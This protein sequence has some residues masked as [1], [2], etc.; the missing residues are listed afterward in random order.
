MTFDA[1]NA[2]LRD[3]P[4]AD[5]R[6]DHLAAT[7]IAVARVVVFE[8]RLAGHLGSWLRALG[9]REL[10]SVYLHCPPVERALRVVER[11]TSRDVRERI[12]GSLD[13][14]AGASFEDVLGH[15][16]ASSDPDLLRVA[17]QLRFAAVRD[18]NDQARIRSVY[19][20]DY[21]DTS[22]FDHCVD[23]SLGD[24]ASTTAAVLRALPA[25]GAST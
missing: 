20:I 7:A 3:D 5:V 22:V 9:R 15:L 17:E 11:A 24:P 19:G 2:L 21:T 18:A 13:D 10:H 1:Y 16:T 4:D 23:T 8:S 14:A 6:G 25:T 12:A